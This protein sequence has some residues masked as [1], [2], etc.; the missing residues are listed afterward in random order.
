MARPN[1]LYLV[2]HDLGK[3]LGCYGARLRSPHLD[4]FGRGGLILDRMVCNSPACSPS[5][6]CAMTGKYAHC[7]GGIGLSHMG[8]P[9]PQT[10]ATITEYLAEAGY[11]TIH[12]GLAH[13][14]LP[15]T[16]HY[17]VELEQDW[18]DWQAP[19][20]IGKALAYL[21][22]RDRSRPFY[23]N[24]G[25][26]EVHPSYWHR[27]EHYERELIREEDVWLPPEFPDSPAARRELRKF[28]ACIHA[29][30]LQCQR[31]IDG[32]QRLGHWQDTLVVITTDHGING[33]RAK[34]TCSM[35]G[36]E[37]TGLIHYA[38]MAQPGRRCT[39]LLQNID[40]APT[41]CEAAG[42]DIPSSI[43]GR[44]FWPLITGGNYTPHQELFLERN[45]H[46]HHR[47]GGQ[48]GIEDVYDPIRS[49]LTERFH[50][51]HNFRPGA[52]PQK[53]LAWHGELPA[54]TSPDGGMRAA[55]PDRPEPR[56]EEEL[57]DLAH[58]PLQTVNL[59][60]RSDYRHVLANLRSRVDR[61]MAQTD[62]FAPSGT[63]PP[64]PLE[65]GWGA[66]QD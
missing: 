12:S 55:F 30:D 9:L 61:W 17:N 64:R 1:I 4:A 7:N 43:Q 37:I 19:Q 57:Y 63:H 58:D 6:S 42:R 8:W 50:Y 44:S 11:E 15:E 59:A 36:M 31:L 5:R 39:H 18:S 65:P 52:R 66:W 20:A 49:I 23:L 14:R 28:E 41:F 46:G 53:H 33:P 35:R 29:F 24:I 48:P 26:Q 10:E 56:P 60:A 21:E 54:E 2:A 25:T 51:L 32:L 38:G 62:D 3:H 45:F 40:F 34:G 13:E 47:R 27:F 16:N 22:T